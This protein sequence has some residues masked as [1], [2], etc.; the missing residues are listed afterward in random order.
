VINHRYVPIP[1]DDESLRAGSGPLFVRDG[2]VMVH[3]DRR[4]PGAGVSALGAYLADR[5]SV[6]TLD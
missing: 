4:S 2:T 5:T 1:L 6:L 3:W